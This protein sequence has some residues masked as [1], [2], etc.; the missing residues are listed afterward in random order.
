[1]GL[2]NNKIVLLRHGESTWNLENRFTGWTDVDLTKKGINEAKSAG[3][4]LKKELIDFDLVYTSRLKRAI[5]TMKLCIQSMDIKNMKPSSSESANAPKQ[6]L[7][8]NRHQA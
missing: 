3:I 6:V 2:K 8:L 7:L 1:M 4:L 5:E